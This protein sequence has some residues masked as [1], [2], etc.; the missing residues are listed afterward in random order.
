MYAFKRNPVPKHLTWDLTDANLKDFF[1]LSIDK[2]GRGQ[3]IDLKIDGNKLAV[4]TEK[5]A[6]FTLWLDGRLANL[7][8]PLEVVVN[9]KL[10]RHPLTPRLATLCESLQ[11]RGDLS[12]A[13][14]CRLDLSVPAAL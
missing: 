11:R 5:V 14:S 10:S 13:A 7:D 2:P 4:R 9:G 3:T 8:E 6:A 1:W 12:L